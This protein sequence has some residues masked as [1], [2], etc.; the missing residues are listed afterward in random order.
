[1]PSGGRAELK[2]VTLTDHGQ[3]MNVAYMSMGVVQSQNTKVKMVRT[4]RKIT[5]VQPSQEVAQK[6]CEAI[7]S[8]GHLSD[9]DRFD[10]QQSCNP[11][12]EHEDFMQISRLGRILFFWD[13]GW[14]Y[15]ARIRFATSQNCIMDMLA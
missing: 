11:S 2:A 6:C 10:S 3:S 7:K 15:A 13:C 5:S 14:A 8:K 12:T 4:E 9:F 1:M